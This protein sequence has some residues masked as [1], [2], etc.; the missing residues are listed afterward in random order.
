M[1]QRLVPVQYMQ[2]NT[3]VALTL[4]AAVAFRACHPFN[5]VY[6]K[7]VVVHFTLLLHL[8]LSLPFAG[9]DG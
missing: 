1:P 2:A 5:F 6:I 4:A 7:T 3:N 9:Y 8:H